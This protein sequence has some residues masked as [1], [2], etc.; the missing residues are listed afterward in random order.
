MIDESPIKKTVFL[1]PILRLI[2]SLFIIMLVLGS[3]CSSPGKQ[4][5]YI[6]N[7]TYY[8]PDAVLRDFE[9]KFGVQ[10]V[11]DMYASNE[12]MFT[13]LK[14]GASG[15]DIV[16]PSEDYVAIM[17]H[18]GMLAKLDKSKIPNFANIDP[19]VLARA[20]FDPG[21]AYS[22]PYMMGAS[23]IA[24]N[25]TKVASYEKSWMLFSRPDL[26]DRCTMLDDMR[27]VLGAALKTLGFS[28]NSKDTAQLA[29]AGDLVRQWKKNIVKF[30]AESFAKGFAAGE[31]WAVHAYAENV[32]REYD[33][34]RTSD[35][36]FFIPREGG[37]MYMDNMVILKEARH[38]DLAHAFINY[39]HDPVV[40][41]RIVDYLGYPS[42][43]AAARK[44][45]TRKPNYELKDLSR[46]ELKEDLGPTL[47][48]YN[49]VWEG[50]RMEK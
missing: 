46:C 24:V 15:Y 4:K 32:F 44:Y 25:K 48:L 31:F 20:D 1:R 14:S 26:A 27:E 42:I 22:V 23:G 16:V 36:E 38:K 11:Y 3:A 28:V 13:K 5:L 40:F 6:Y 9:K 7:W 21:N 2:L 45:C 17:I 33:S 37:P 39:V 50:I 34:T 10:I 43:N 12:D 19:A 49:K 30:D 47:D 29:K 18:E 35:V 41:A 8:M